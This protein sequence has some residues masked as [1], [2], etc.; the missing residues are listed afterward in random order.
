LLIAIVRAALGDFDSV[1]F[2]SKNKT[3][4]F[5]YPNAKPSRKIMLQR[6]RLAY[7]IIPVSIYTLLIHS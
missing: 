5:V 6:L 2:N 4:T 1:A 7:A 3:V